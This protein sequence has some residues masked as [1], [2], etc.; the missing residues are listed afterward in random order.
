MVVGEH[1]TGTA[2]LGGVGDNCAEW[3]ISAAFVAL[4]TRQMEASRLIID[5]SDPKALAS[6]SCLT[7]AAAEERFGGCK[8]IELQ[9]VFGTL[10]PHAVFV[11]RGADT[12]ACN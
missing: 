4:V 2:M 8:P 6:R 11:C 1:E 12:K 9:R 10:I 7:E 5:M 3:K